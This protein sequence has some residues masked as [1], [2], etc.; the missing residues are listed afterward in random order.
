MTSN[1]VP[2]IS[3]IVPVRN[4][5]RRLEMCLRSIRRNIGTTATHEIIVVDNGSTDQSAE[6][7]RSFGARVLSMPDRVPVAELRNRAARQATGDAL[8]FVDADNEIVSGWVIAAV[9]TLR[10]PAAG[11]VGALCLAPID[12]TWVQ[13]AYGYMRG[14]AQGQHETEWLGSGNLV[15]WRQTF[16]SVHGFDASLQAC[17]DVDF[18]RKLRAAGKKLISDSR[19]KSIHHGDPETLAALFASERWRGRDN[20]RVGLRAPM[21]SLPSTILPVIDVAMIAAV[22]LGLLATPL[23]AS[24]GLVAALAALMVISGGVW[25]RVF[26]AMVRDRAVRGLAIAQVLAVTCVYD[27]ARAAALISPAPHRSARTDLASA[28]S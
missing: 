9:E 4:D 21:T 7:A 22:A 2:R 13:R 10:T 5:A 27:L 8:A 16:E 17:E 19:L 20:L 6:V 26:R 3:F 14:R 23:A 12:G 1:G 25:L 24:Y 28:A 11:A 15:V 18:S